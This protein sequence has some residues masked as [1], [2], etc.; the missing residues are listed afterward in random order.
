MGDMDDFLPITIF[1]V[2]EVDCQTNMLGKV[3]MLLSQF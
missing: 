2:L 1:C 3:K